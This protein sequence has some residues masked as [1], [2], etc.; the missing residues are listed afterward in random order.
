MRTDGYLMQSEN[1][2]GPN[3][4]KPI[5]VSKS[6]GTCQAHDIWVAALTHPGQQENPSLANRKNQEVLNFTSLF[7]KPLSYLHYIIIF[8]IV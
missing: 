1:L 4:Q 2:D 3:L 5:T 8:T 7:S 6:W